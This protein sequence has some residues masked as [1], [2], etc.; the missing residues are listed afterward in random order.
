MQLEAT[1]REYVARRPFSYPVLLDPED[2]LGPR[3]QIYGLPTV[4]IVDRQGVISFLET[5]VSDTATLRRELAAVG[6][7]I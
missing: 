7:G 3:Y 6:A 4:M 2:S 5:G 1:V